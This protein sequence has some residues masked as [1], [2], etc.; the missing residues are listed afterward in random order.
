MRKMRQLARER[1]QRSKMIQQKQRDRDREQRQRQIHD[2]FFVTL[3]ARALPLRE[4]RGEISF[5]LPG[6]R[7]LEVQSSNEVLGFFDVAGWTLDGTW[8][9]YEWARDEW[10][11]YF[12]FEIADCPIGKCLCERQTGLWEDIHREIDPCDFLLA[13]DGAIIGFYS[14]VSDRYE[15]VKRRELEIQEEQYNAEAFDSARQKVDDLGGHYLSDSEVDAVW[16]EVSVLSM[17]GR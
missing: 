15:P 9:R 6:Q 16:C 10:T 4:S 8:R 1:R 13:P 3:P 14:A 17:S 2:L 12:I 7:Q 11:D 5:V